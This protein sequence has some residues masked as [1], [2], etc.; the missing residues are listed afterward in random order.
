MNLTRNILLLAVGFFI[1][2]NTLEA[3][4]SCRIVFPER[5]QAAPKMAYLFDGV[6]SQ[7][8]TLPSM[9]L[10]EVIELPDGELTIAMT[11]NEI[12]DPKVLSPSAPLL[13]IPEMVM[14]FYI[15]MTADPS[16][17]D[18]PVKMNLVDT[19]GGKLKPGETL[20]YNLTQ[21]RIAA[22]LG[23]ADMSLI[24]RAGRFPKTPLQPAATTLPGSLIR[25]MAKAHLHRSQNNS[26][27]TTP[28]ET[29]GIH[30][31]FRGKIAQNLLL[32]GLS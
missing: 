4:R 21:H 17:H 32:S 23:S 2:A 20:W 3:K 30:G 18:M 24:L 26:G 7:R 6:K 5:P 27:G 16:N 31:Q 1:L 28:K 22:K 12:S 8:V 13:K 29:S 9:N 15:I 19:G 25:R 14:D 11:T 10:S